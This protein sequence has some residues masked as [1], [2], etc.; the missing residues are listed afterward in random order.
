MRSLSKDNQ[1]EYLPRQHLK[2][3]VKHKQGIQFY[4]H[5]LN[6]GKLQ[7]SFAAMQRSLAYYIHDLHQVNEETDQR[8]RELA[9]ATKQVEEADSRKLAFIQ[10]I[11]HQIRTPL[12]IITGFSQILSD[13][14]NLVG[15]DEMKAI[16]TAMQENSHNIVHIV[17][18]LINNGSFVVNN[19]YFK[20]KTA[21]FLTGFESFELYKV[22]IESF[23]FFVCSE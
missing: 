20:D 10:D 4:P 13:G 7:D 9:L 14:Y 16:I 11:T 19:P 5:L 23:M 15:E 17:N 1:S 6:N 21:Y 22:L 2:S 12:N 18:K 8:N 3:L